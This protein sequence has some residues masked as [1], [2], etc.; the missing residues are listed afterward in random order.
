VCVCPDGTP[1]KL[2]DVSKIT[3]MGWKVGISLEEGLKQT[4][5]LPALA[6]DVEPFLSGIY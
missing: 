6:K 1:G 2:L 4:L 5:D 3:Q